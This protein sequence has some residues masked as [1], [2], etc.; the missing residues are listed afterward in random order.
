MKGLFIDASITEIKKNYLKIADYFK[1]RDSSFSALFLTVDTASSV[2]KSMEQDAL[3]TMTQ[4]GYTVEK[5]HSF[6]RKA[7]FKKLQNEKPDFVF[8]DSMNVYN[9]LWNAICKECGVPVYFYPHGFQIDNLYYNKIAIANKL[10]KVIRYTYGLFNI[11]RLLGSSFGR[12]FK[13]YKNYISS[14]ADMKD[15]ALDD[16]SLYP[17]VVFIFSDYYRKFWERKYGIRNVKYEF[18]MPYDFSMVEKVLS[19]PQ[20]NAVCYITQTLHEDGRYTKNGYFDLLRSLRPLATEVDK[21]YIKLHPRVES[22]MY[23]EAFAGLENVEIIREFPHCT[24]YFTHYSS[25]AYTA[26]LVSGKTI[27]YELPGQPTHEVYKEVATEIVYNVPQLIDA[28]KRQL[29]SASLSFEQRK[30]IISKYATYTGISP[31]EV[32]YNAIYSQ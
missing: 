12:I 22:D 29:T 23:E 26:A 13:A 31:Y 1:E 18:I 28:L 17:D 15:S 9:Q 30:K 11:S 19:K 7:I 27:L 20:E 4:K 10:T 32:L 25:L 16:P 21:L 3:F 2:V 8:I 6:N 14:G 24:C 5:F